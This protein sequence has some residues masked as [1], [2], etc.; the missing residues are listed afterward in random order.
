MPGSDPALPVRGSHARDETG[1]C[2]AGDDDVHQEGNCGQERARRQSGSGSHHG[3][4]PDHYTRQ[5]AAASRRYWPSK[6][7]A[8]AGPAQ[9]GHVSEGKRHAAAHYVPTPL[10][11]TVSAVSSDDL[12]TPP[13]PLTRLAQTARWCRGSA[14]GL[15]RLAVPRTSP[16]GGPV[17]CPTAASPAWRPARLPRSTPRTPRDPVLRCGPIL[18]QG[19]GVPRCVAGQRGAPDAVAGSKWGYRYTGEWRLDAEHQEIKEHSLAMFTSQLTET[20]CS[21]G[22]GS[23]SIDSLPDH[24]FRSAGRPGAAGPARR[25]AGPGRHRRHH[26]QR[27][28]PADTL[29]RALEAT[30][31]GSRCSAAPR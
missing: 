6:A 3:S 17:T 29:R 8:G 11:R 31:D 9:H 30:V 2:Q 1:R 22:T 28:R 25:P 5:V 4:S 14:W 12:K 15:R 19:R 23:R 27:S 13:M 10:P 7:R 21:S 24:R 16:P 20:G 18:R 26:D